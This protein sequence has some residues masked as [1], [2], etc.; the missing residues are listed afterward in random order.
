LPFEEIFNSC[1]F[2]HIVYMV[3]ENTMLPAH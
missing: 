2:G 1:N 3:L